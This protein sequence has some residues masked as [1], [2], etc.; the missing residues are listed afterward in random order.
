MRIRHRFPKAERL[1]GS[2]QIARL[3]AQGKSSR[4]GGLVL[5]YLPVPCSARQAH[6]QVVFIVPKRL[7]PHAH[8]RNALKR[9]LREA[10]RHHKEL[11]AAAPSS[12]YWH[13]ALLLVDRRVAQKG[14]QALH[15]WLE[16]HLRSLAWWQAAAEQEVSALA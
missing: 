12:F 8:Q 5:R 6:H 11:L 14:F 16:S 1:C 15:G 2:Q 13:I 7:F 3:F 10:F 9:Q 4:K